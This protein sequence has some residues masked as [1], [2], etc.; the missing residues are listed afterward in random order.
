MT[1]R[2]QLAAALTSVLVLA[3][4]SDDEPGET[5]NPGPPMTPTSSA[6]SA[7]PNPGTAKA[8]PVKEPLDASAFVAEPCKSLTEGQRTDFALEQGEPD[9]SSESGVP[10]EACMY[11]NHEAQ[12]R[13]RVVYTPEL[14]NGL[15]HLY[16]QNAA[17]SWKYWE[18]TEV[19]GH[20][21]V[22]AMDEPPGTDC[23][24]S[25]GLNDSLYFDVSVLAE[26]GDGRTAAENVASAVLATIKAGGA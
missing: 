15:S 18:P 6:S 24:L 21:A 7:S 25:V 3:A 22:I 19:D 8:P 11:T 20:P 10:G 2:I 17:G 23:S 26:S 13:V 12:V 1:A 14:K 16:E 4:C 9:L 5:N